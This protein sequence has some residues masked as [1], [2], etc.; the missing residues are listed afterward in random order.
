MAGSNSMN[1]TPYIAVKGAANAIAF[2][3]KVFGAK[4]DFRLED[5]D[6]RIGHAEI[7]IGD[8][9]LMISDEYPDFGALAPASVGGTPVKLHLYVEDVDATMK[10]AENAGA[11]VLR[12][13]QDQFYGDRAGMIADPFG[14]QW[15]LAT[16]K[17]NVSP[18]EMQKRFEESYR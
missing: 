12:P 6:K 13:A 1:L 14:H 11:T 10:K 5:Q 18:E 7:S 4:E 9:R 2:Y 8:G 3:K 15:F 17:E 16:R